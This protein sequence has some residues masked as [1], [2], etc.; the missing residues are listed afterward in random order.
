MDN[1]PVKS[2][3]WVRN[4]EFRRVHQ[5]KR[6]DVNT[7]CPVSCGVCCRDD[8]TYTFETDFG[9]IEDCAWIAKRPGV[10]GP[11]YCD[12]YLNKKVVKDACPLTCGLC[13]NSISVYPT[14]SP[15]PTASPISTLIVNKKKSS[16]A[17]KSVK[18]TQRPSIS[19]P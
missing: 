7:A 10:R 13:K 18:T 15:R 14:V 5:C 16:K 17:P 19:L 9:P 3:R 1:D 4:K 2:C 8:V 6:V 11:R 12:E